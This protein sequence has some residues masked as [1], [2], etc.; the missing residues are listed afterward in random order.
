MKGL[1]TLVNCNLFHKKSSNF[2]DIVKGENGA[3]ENVSLK[4]EEVQ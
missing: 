1:L 2:T 4:T 3:K